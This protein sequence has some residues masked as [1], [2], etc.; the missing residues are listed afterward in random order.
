VVQI[1]KGRA[2]KTIRLARHASRYA[3]C[4]QKRVEREDECDHCVSGTLFN[5]KDTHTHEGDKHSDGRRDHGIL[6]CE[7]CSHRRGTKER[8]QS[9]SEKEE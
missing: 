6:D 5:L 9:L 7:D 2:R 8:D 1:G 4:R 3:K